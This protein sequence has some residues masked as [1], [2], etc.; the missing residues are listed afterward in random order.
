LTGITPDMVAG[1]HIDPAAV[2]LFASNA[3]V[4]IAH[5][6]KFDRPFAERYSPEFQHLAW[7]CSAT[8]VDWRA[9]G[10]DGARLAHLLNHIG[11]FYDAHRALDDCRAVLEILDFKLP[12]IGATI[13]SLLVDEARRQTVRIWALNAPFALKED[14]K[15]RHYRWNDGSDGRPRSWFVDVDESCHREEIEY[16]RKHIFRRDDVDFHIQ[17][18]DAFLRFSNRI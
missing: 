17:R 2:A 18:L 8:Q 9:L 5:N 12:S 1:H 14:L 10:F 6:A 13:L 3:N 15:R 16:L 4:V 7:A 11:L